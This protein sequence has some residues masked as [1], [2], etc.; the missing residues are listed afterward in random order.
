MILQ[1]ASKIMSEGIH[2]PIPEDIPEP[3]K[4]LLQSCWQ[5]DPSQRPSFSIICQQIHLWND[6]NYS[7]SSVQ[8][9]TSPL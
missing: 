7:H 3:M 8:Y 5:F 6:K 1:A 2:P 9:A 4:Q